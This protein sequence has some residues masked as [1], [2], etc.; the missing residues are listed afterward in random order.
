ME[1][2]SA[3]KKFGVNLAHLQTLWEFQRCLKNEKHQAVSKMNFEGRAKI[4]YKNNE[5]EWCSI[6]IQNMIIVFKAENDGYWED[7][8]LTLNSKR[9]K[10]YVKVGNIVTL[11]FRSP[12][13]AF[14]NELKLDFDGDDKLVQPFA[15]RISEEPENT[16]HAYNLISEDDSVKSSTIRKEQ[17]EL[18]AASL[19][20]NRSR[21]ALT[22]ENVDFNTQ[23][24]MLRLK[25]RNIDENQYVKVILKTIVK[26]LYKPI[27]YRKLDNSEEKLRA[28]NGLNKKLRSESCGSSVE[29]Q[30]LIIKRKYLSIPFEIKMSSSMMG[31]VA[32]PIKK[33]IIDDP[34]DLPN[35]YSETP[36]G[37]LFSTTPGGTRIVYEKNFLMTLRNSPNSKTPPTCVI[38][39]YL[40]KGSTG[41]PPKKTYYNPHY[42]NSRRS[43][44]PKIRRDS[45]N[46]R[47]NSAQDNDDQFQMEL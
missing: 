43:S 22:V 47:R 25:G 6:T 27:S 19:T 17:S 7:S 46:G 38:P 10:N 1:Q 2:D 24:C 31:T 33:V 20:S 39:D 4:S 12:H 32:I 42:S 36:G 34:S 26:A 29:I 45:N 13:I 3:T 35:H 21:T 5:F 41:T 15:G 16:W 40:V 28:F 30:V 14:G 44:Y 11:L 18:S 8:E 9:I 37:T 23:A